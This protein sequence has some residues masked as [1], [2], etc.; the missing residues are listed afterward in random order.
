[1]LNRRLGELQRKSGI[2]VYRTLV[3][4]LKFCRSGPLLVV[5]PDGTWYHSVTPEVLGRI[6]DEHLAGG[7]IVEDFAFAANPMRDPD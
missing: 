4:C 1:L 2:Y 7:R 6:I 5:Y 3:G